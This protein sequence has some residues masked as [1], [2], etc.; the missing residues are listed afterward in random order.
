MPDAD[1]QPT[2]LP[3]HAPV[4]DDADVVEGTIV[5]N[6]TLILELTLTLEESRLLSAAASAAKI[7]AARYTKQTALEAARRFQDAQG[8]SAAD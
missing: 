7:S 2:S 6:P 4:L 1:A 8:A 5:P 3:P